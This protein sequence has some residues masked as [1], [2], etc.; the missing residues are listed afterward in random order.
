MPYF[1][2]HRNYTLSTIKGHSITFKK[3]ERVWVPLDVAVDAIAIGAVPEEH[4]DVLPP[5][6]PEQVKLSS[7]AERDLFFAAFEKLL[8]RSNRGD[9]TA[10]GHPHPKKLEEIVGYELPQK[11]R[12]ALWI[13]YNAKKNDEL[14]QAK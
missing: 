8:L 5:E 12:D 4:L 7:E 9:F 10:S 2:F 11:Q 14:E 13:A 1:T 3:G 6:T